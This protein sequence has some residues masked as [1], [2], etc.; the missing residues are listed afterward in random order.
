VIIVVTGGRDLQDAHLVFGALDALHRQER[1]TGLY[2]GAALGAD[3][4]AEAW[5]RRR[6]VPVEPVPADWEEAERRGNRKAAGPIRN[7]R[8][9]KVAKEAGAT[10]VV[11]F[12]GG[13][14]TSDCV[15]KA[16]GA[17]LK[18]EDFRKEGPMKNERGSISFLGLLAVLFIALK[19]TNV[20]D[21]SWWLVLA[22]LWAPAMAAGAVAVFCVFMGAV[23]HIFERPKSGLSRRSRG[24]LL[25]LSL[26]AI[27]ELAH[28]EEEGSKKRDG[29]PSY[30]ETR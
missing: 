23:V 19:L 13:K 17:G 26:I 15:Q 27:A 7:T 21:W 3:L 10:V 14:G 6:G 29:K 2:H 24:V 12:P 1:I 25:V 20:V 9:I 22:P 5:A 11:A 4:L 28:H 8:M 16:L 30:A 18:L